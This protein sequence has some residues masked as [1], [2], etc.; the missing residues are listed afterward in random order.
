[1]K[2][3]RK[4]W[5]WTVG[6]ILVAL[7]LSAAPSAAAKGGKS[8]IGYLSITGVTEGCSDVKN[9]ENSCLIYGFQ[10]GVTTSGSSLGGGGGGAVKATFS[11]TITKPIDRAS[12]TILADT[13]MGT[14]IKDATIRFAQDGSFKSSYSLQLSNVIVTGVRQYYDAL[15]PDQ[16]NLGQLEDVTF[17]FG[18][19]NWV[20]EPDIQFC[21][22]PPDNK[23]CVT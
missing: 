16:A 12:V 5:F 17:E 14:H 9:N 13:A 4:R 20:W 10:Q 21:F 6:I 23:Q 3:S 8:T 19:I 2:V 7:F 1:M 11:L 15:D 22:S 18:R